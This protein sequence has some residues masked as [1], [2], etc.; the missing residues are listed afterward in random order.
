MKEQSAHQMINEFDFP[1]KPICVGDI[2][3]G[4]NECPQKLSN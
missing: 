4:P 1:K 2:I 3:P